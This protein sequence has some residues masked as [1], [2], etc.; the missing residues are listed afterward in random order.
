MTEEIEFSFERD[1]DVPS[2]LVYSDWLQ[3]KEGETERV[4]AIRRQAEF[5]MQNKLPIELDISIDD[6]NSIT[7]VLIPPGQFLMGNR[8]KQQVH[9]KKAF[10][11]GKYPV[12]QNQY[13]IVT[14]DNPSYFSQSKDS[15]NRPVE[16]VGWEDMMKF[17]DMFEENSSFSFM[18]VRTPKILKISKISVG[19][20]REEEWEYACRAGTT[21]VYPWGD[22]LGPNLANIHKSRLPSHANQ[23]SPVGCYPPNNWGLYDMIGNVSEACSNRYKWSDKVHYVKNEHIIRRKLRVVS[24]RGGDWSM[25]LKNI[26]SACN[27]LVENMYTDSYNWLGF[28]CKAQIEFN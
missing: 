18:F 16:G 28:R 12:T 24:V 13:K 3:E 14:G 21:T 2:R 4:T 26:N 6:Y 23:T 11:L 19:L 5:A 17:C 10:W 8:R 1:M 9:V 27:S 25:R 20:P 7:F 22:S 15:G